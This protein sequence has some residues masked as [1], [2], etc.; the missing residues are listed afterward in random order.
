MNSSHYGWESPLP[1]GSCNYIAPAIFKIL[2]RESQFRILELG[3]GNG[4]LCEELYRRGFS[5]VG[6]EPSIDG[7]NAARSLA[8]GVPF[9]QLGVDDDLG[10]LTSK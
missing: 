10:I 9:F 2:D 6:V 3:C 4:A 5:V 7:V 1:P 8:P